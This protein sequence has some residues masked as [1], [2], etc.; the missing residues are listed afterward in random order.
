MISTVINKAIKVSLTTRSFHRA[1]LINDIRVVDPG[2]PAG[3]GSVLLKLE[4]GSSLFF[5]NLNMSYPDSG[6]TGDYDR[7]CSCIRVESGSGQSESGS[8]TRRA[9]S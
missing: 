7:V 1:R 5:N 8:G 4:S 6:G 9:V 2:V 3:S